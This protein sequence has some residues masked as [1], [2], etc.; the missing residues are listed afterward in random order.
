MLLVELPGAG[1]EK[2]HDPAHRLDVFR[3]RDVG[4][5]LFEIRKMVGRHGRPAKGLAECLMRYGK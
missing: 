4:E 3:H 1:Q 2:V 5:R